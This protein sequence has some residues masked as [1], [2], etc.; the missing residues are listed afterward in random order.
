MICLSVYKVIL[1]IANVDI[2]RVYFLVKLG[3]T[4]VS[5]CSNTCA[6]FEEICRYG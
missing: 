6:S 4:T 2:V 1:K 5:S 3:K